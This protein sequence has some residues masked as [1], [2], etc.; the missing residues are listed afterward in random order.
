MMSHSKLSG[1]E[2]GRE[3]EHATEHPLKALISAAVELCL[4]RIGPQHMPASPA[5]LGLLLLLNLLLGMLMMTL[6]GIGISMAALQT[7]FELGFMLGLLYL[8]LRLRGRLQRFAQTGTALL[9]SGLLINSLALPLVAW[10]HRTASAESGLLVLILIF[11]SIVVL[12]HIIRH[13]FEVD[14]N[15]GIAAGVLYT[16][17][18]WSLSSMLFPVPA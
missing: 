2:P 7:L 4:L 5:L 10:N 18:T 16:L 13:A 1:P 12:G 6:V 3:P 15:L 14:L 8:A 9:L 17:S 11:W